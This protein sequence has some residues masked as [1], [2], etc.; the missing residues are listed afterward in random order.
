MNPYSV[1]GEYRQYLR[2]KYVLLGG[3]LLLLPVA[4]FLSITAG[5]VHIGS[6]EII[7][8]LL[9]GEAPDT[10]VRIIYH[11]RLPQSVAAVLA[12]AGLAISGASM[13]AVLRNPLCSPFTLGISGA[14]AFGAAS[15]IFLRDG[16][17][18]ATA[19][20]ATFAET[21]AF[22]PAGSV[23]AGAFLSAILATGLILTLSGRR[24][25]K[26]E[27]IILI[28][29][30]LGAFYGAGTMMLQYFATE[31]QLAAMVYW[32]FGDTQRANWYSVGIMSL[33]VAVSVIYFISQSRNY[34]TLALGE[35]NALSLGVPVRR[36]RLGTMFFASLLTS[37]L[38]TSLGII[39][40]V[41]LVVPHTVRLW[42]G[43]DNRFVLLCS[44]VCGALLLLIAD[45]AARTITPGCQMPVSILTAFLGAPFFLLMLLNKSEV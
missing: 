10:H 15:V 25:A 41:G 27:T 8:I 32:T 22:L 36:M 14:A 12:G 31:R 29:V 2:Q 40:F 35:E 17:V 16:I 3:M 28:G 37:V 23:T 13:Q 11:F 19:I 1:T 20:T 18:T 44:L 33:F 24:S 26:P 30:A 7:R 9:G 5:P 4:F 6:A 45:T 39:G 43:S 34:N 21:T 38:V 42:V